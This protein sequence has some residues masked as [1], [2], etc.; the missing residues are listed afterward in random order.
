MSELQRQLIE[1]LIS[2]PRTAQQLAWDLNVDWEEV[3]DALEALSAETLVRPN[4]G[5]APGDMDCGS[6]GAS[7]LG[8]ESGDRCDAY[9]AGGSLLCG[10]PLY[11]L[12]VYV[13]CGGPISKA[14]EAAA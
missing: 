14:L 7:Y 2:K 9:L 12:C 3:V 4:V 10:G 8:A 5:V 1:E 6:C 11:D 13:Y